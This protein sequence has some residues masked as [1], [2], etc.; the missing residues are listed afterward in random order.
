M[1]NLTTALLPEIKKHQSITL[2]SGKGVFNW[3]DVKNIAEAI[4]F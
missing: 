2:P 4:A 3:I 1:Q